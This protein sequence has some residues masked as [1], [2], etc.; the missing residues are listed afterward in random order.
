MDA[1]TFWRDFE[2]AY[3]L[4]A[5]GLIPDLIS[6]QAYREAATNL[7]LAPEWRDQLDRLNRMRAVHGTTALEGNPL[8]EEQVS[9]QLRLSDEDHR[10]GHRAFTRE[11]LQIENADRAQAWVKQRFTPGGEP[12]DLGDLF[13]MHRM[14]TEQSDEHNN[15]PGQLRTARV[16]VGSLDTG[17]VHTG[18]PHEGLLR[19]MEGFVEF[20][21]STRFR[22][23][24]PITQA[25]LAHFFL[26]TIHPFGDGNGRVSRLLEA[27]I[28]YRGDYNVH[29]F[30][31]LS[32]FFYRNQ[33]NYYTVLQESRRR[34]PFD[35]TPFIEFGIRGFGDEL[36][37][38]NNFIK[39][40]MNRLLYRQ[41]LVASYNIRVSERRRALNEREYQLLD[42]LLSETEPL[43]PFSEIPSRRIEFSELVNSRYVRTAYKDV[44]SR[45]F[46]REVSRL[47]E[48]G[49]I[50]L[51]RG[52]GRA[53]WIVELDFG[54]IAKYPI[55]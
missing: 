38:I 44:T 50:R 46:T 39:T 18:A 28:L 14:I 54:A 19:I 2:F 47:E 13:T 35:V 53:E 12:F 31:G 27:G 25:L 5:E 3:R 32:N 15:I 29:G 21:R 49:F 4:A 17:G 40:K 6:I 10:P 36:S 20:T 1:T 37:G 34:Y 55:S 43:D 41:M 52:R 22:Q 11:Q 24:N 30:Y 45:T 26:V 33:A 48:M 7:F 16:R 42:Y 51:E 9:D 23:E 8:S